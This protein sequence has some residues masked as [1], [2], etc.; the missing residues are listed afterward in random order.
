[1]QG[2]LSSEVTEA[3][4]RGRGLG[5]PAARRM[6]ADPAEQLHTGVG[7]GG[8]E[9]MGRATGM[10]V[11]SGSAISSTGCVTSARDAVRLPSS[12]TRARCS[13]RKLRHSGP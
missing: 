4:D 13:V 1:M 9:L 12:W 6:V 5:G 10:S 3:G 7:Q 8:R 2:R 11:S